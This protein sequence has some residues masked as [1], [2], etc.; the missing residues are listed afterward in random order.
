M[1]I[2]ENLD[3]YWQ[4][5]PGQDQKR[6]FTKESHLR[7]QLNIKQ[8]SD[9]NYKRL[10]TLKRGRHYICNT[11]NYDILFSPEYADKMFYTNMGRRVENES[12]DAICQLLYR[13][14]QIA[15]V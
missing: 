11:I 13:G 7:E 9:D 4:C 1:N 2:D 10:Q 8:L 14:E 12:S 15:N 6:W 3:K 5:I